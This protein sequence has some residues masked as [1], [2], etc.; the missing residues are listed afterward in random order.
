MAADK[1]RLTRM[2]TS[3][4]SAFIRVYPRPVIGFPSRREWIGGVP[5]LD[6][7]FDQ[8]DVESS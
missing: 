7:M 1:R 6:R 8:V 5:V 4:L 3:E 2:K